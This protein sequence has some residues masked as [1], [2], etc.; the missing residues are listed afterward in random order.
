V[1]VYIG[2]Q[3][4]RVTLRGNTFA[5]LVESDVVNESATE[6]DTSK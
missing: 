6:D 5:D 3:A 4:Q 1:G 2:P